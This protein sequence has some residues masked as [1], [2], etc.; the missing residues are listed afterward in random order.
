VVAVTLI[1]SVFNQAEPSAL[2]SDH[3]LIGHTVFAVTNLP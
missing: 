3:E 1:L 2:L